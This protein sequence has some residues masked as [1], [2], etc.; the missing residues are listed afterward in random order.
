MRVYC[1]ILRISRM[2]AYDK[3]MRLIYVT[4]YYAGAK[5]FYFERSHIH[6]IIAHTLPV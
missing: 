2:I 4:L 3:V 5:R 1:K 6:I